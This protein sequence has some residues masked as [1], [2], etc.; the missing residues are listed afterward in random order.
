M[1]VMV[2]TAGERTDLRRRNLLMSCAVHNYV[3]GDRLFAVQIVDRGRRNRW[4]FHVCFAFGR[5]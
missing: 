1:Y 5:T 4:D 3:F 2:V